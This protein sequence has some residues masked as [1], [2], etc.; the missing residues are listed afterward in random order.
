MLNDKSKETQPTASSLQEIIAITEEI[1]FNTQGSWF[2]GHS[3]C[4]YELIPTVF[5]K[6]SKQTDAPYY[7]E[8]QLLEEFVRRHPKAK[9]EHTNTLELLAYAQHYGLPTRLLD[10][11]ENLLVATY[12]ACCDYNTK[13]V[14][15]GEI[16]ILKKPKAP[17]SF[18]DLICGGFAKNIIK[19]SI[20]GNNITNLVD[21]VVNLTNESTSLSDFIHINDTCIKNISKENSWEFV[22]QQQELDISFKT[23]GIDA[24]LSSSFFT[25][26]PPQINKRLISQSGCFTVHSGKVLNNK[27]VFPFKPAKSSNGKKIKSII[28]PSCSKEKIIKTLNTCG[29]NKAKLFPELEHQT[30]DIKNNCM[31]KN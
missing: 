22:K 4:T 18:L 10:W 29:I 13:D 21:I 1:T 25:Y 30:Q 23:K 11:T 8:S 3:D 31:Y 17:S 16:F 9:Q 20:E 2:R 6:S 26:Y 28:I 12:F 19:A 5:R 14:K 7:D 27:V 24:K 15:D